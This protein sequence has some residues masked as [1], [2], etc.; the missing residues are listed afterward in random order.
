[1]ISAQELYG[2]LWVEDSGLD[3]ELARSLEPRA[4]STL[5]DAFA[6]LGPRPDDLVVDAGCRDASY[7]VELV[8]RF[9]V[10]IL[11]LDPVPLYVEQARRRAAEA[12]LEDRI[13]VHE[14]AVETIPLEDGAAA[15]VWCRDVLT[16]VDL[17]AGLAEFRRVL[18]PGGRAL[19]YQT[20]GTDTI[21]PK[22]AARLYAATATVPANM[23]PG[24]FE[25]TAAEAGLAVASVDPIDSEWRE[26][27]IEEGEW[28]PSEDLLAVA[29][30]RRREPEL[31]DRYGRNRLEARL[32]GD[33]WGIYQLLGKLRPTIYVL[34]RPDG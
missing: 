34:E 10:R 8:R 13:E 16:H 31:A 15:F 9:D 23:D 2:R 32:G 22:E 19:V 29:R 12:E 11:A 4:R 3:A 1:M 5:F 6:A 28:N 26:A 24:Y 30:M 33:L 18:E 20:F 25:R 14:G 21:E 7:A 27:M 17:R